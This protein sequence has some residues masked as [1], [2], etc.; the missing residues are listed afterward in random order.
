MYLL[1]SNLLIALCDADHEHHDRAREWFRRN[2]AEGWATCPLTESALLRIMGHPG[3][4]GGPGSPAPLRALLQQ[5]RS[6]R[7]H[8]F[9]PDSITIADETLLPD[10]NGV[11]PKELTDLYL[12]ALAVANNSRFATF[13][14]RV[15]PEKVARGREHLVSIDTR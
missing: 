14:N 5:L 10:L 11:G 3:Y 9:L 4:P 13:D 8:A 15:D 12:L 6:H 1:D 2:A 7:S